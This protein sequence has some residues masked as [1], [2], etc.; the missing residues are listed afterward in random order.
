M[1]ALVKGQRFKYSNSPNGFNY[2][3]PIKGLR[4]YATDPD[5]QNGFKI[6]RVAFVNSVNLLPMYYDGGVRKLT[7]P[8]RSPAGGWP[9]ITS[10]MDSARAGDIVVF[11]Q[12]SNLDYTGLGEIMSAD[13][14]GVRIEYISPGVPFSNV[15]VGIFKSVDSLK[16]Q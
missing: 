1:P 8:R 12:G 3:N 4:Y 13:S 11:Y 2:V 10:A 5:Y 6:D 9:S 7:L 16:K 15:N 14:S